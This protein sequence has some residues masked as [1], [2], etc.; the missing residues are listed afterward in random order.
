MTDFRL[1]AFTSNGYALNRSG[2]YSTGATE[3]LLYWFGTSL[4]DDAIQEILG[5]VYP[6]IFD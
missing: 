4:D 6:E 2:D 3:T 5:N 1:P